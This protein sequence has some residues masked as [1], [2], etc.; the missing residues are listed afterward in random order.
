MVVNKEYY[1]EGNENIQKNKT[2][3]KQIILTHTSCT[4]DE[5]LTKIETRYNGKYNRLP[6]FF[7]SQSGEIYQHFDPKYYSL[8]MWEHQIEKHSITICLENVGWLSKDLALDKYFTWKGS[9][10]LGDVV[11][12]PWRNKKHWA[13]YSEEQYVKLAELIDYLCIEHNIIKDFIGNNIV[14]NKPNVQRGIL[15]RSNYTKNNYDLSPA[16]DFKKINE[17][18]NKEYKHEQLR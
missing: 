13:T 10:Y 17:L 15:N 5:Y 11:E 16:A 12:I 7:I 2:K 18:I 3:K 14:I 4:I 9:E 8:M 1:F 6:C